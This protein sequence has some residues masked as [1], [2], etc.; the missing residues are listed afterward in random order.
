[1]Q[2][3]YC[4]CLS[5]VTFEKITVCVIVIGPNKYVI[6]ILPKSRSAL[7]FF[8]VCQTWTSATPDWISL[9]QDINSMSD[10][11]FSVPHKRRQVSTGRGKNGPMFKWLL[12][13][14]CWS[15]SQSVFFLRKLRVWRQTPES[16]IYQRQK[17]PFGVAQ[18]ETYNTRSPEFYDEYCWYIQHIEL[19]F[20]IC[21][22][23]RSI[24]FSCLIQVIF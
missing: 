22:T 9:S 17:F 12:Q 7:H 20:N 2:V 8:S 11:V 15:W 13:L 19:T 24:D 21:I 6:C 14:P 1:M 3:L 16:F 10:G 5:F 23:I 18:K 4:K